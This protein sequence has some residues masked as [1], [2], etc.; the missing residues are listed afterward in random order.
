MSTVERNLNAELDRRM[1]APS[2]HCGNKIFPSET[3]PRNEVLKVIDVFETKRSR[4][5]KLRSYQSG[6]ANNDLCD[7]DCST[8]LRSSAKKRR[9]SV[10]IESQ[11]GK[12][13]INRGYV[14]EEETG[15]DRLDRLR[16]SHLV[17]SRRTG[18][19]GSMELRRILIRRRTAGVHS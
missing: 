11:S 6:R 2:L 19:D 12:R 1:L 16:E 17:I 5:R 3:G 7:A 15:C 13:R 4:R 14:T 9:S 8:K 10:L 18:T